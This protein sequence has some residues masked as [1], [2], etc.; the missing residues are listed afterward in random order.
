MTYEENLRL[1]QFVL[2]RRSHHTYV[3]YC[4]SEREHTA[5]PAPFFFI[6]EYFRPGLT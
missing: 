3:K 5:V 4:L 1:R 6:I 2:K